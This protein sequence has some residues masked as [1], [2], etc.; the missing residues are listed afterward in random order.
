VAWW[1]FVLFVGG[2]RL[3]LQLWCV[4]VAVGWRLTGK[5]HGWGVL[6]GL[7]RVLV[8]NGVVLL[9][10]MAGDRVGR[11][12]QLDWPFS[13]DGDAELIAWVGGRGECECCG[14]LGRCEGLFAE[15]RSWSQQQGWA[16]WRR[17]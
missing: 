1:V 3:R 13:V 2:L 10:W 16:C 17:A 5:E 9:I 11:V 6:A 7:G 15:G 4:M 8:G 14:L 12:C